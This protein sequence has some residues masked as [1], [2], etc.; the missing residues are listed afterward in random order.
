MFY[1]QQFLCTLLIELAGVAGITGILYLY[2]TL[3]TRKKK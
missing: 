1:I 2:W 3:M